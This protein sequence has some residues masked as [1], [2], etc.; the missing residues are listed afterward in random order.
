[1][2]RYEEGY[3]NIYFP[4]TKGWLL[5]EMRDDEINN[6]RQYRE[7]YFEEELDG[8]KEKCQPHMLSAWDDHTEGG[9][10]S[11]GAITEA[12]EGPVVD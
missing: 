4:G 7:I 6:Q 9:Y 11:S 12:S 5:L 2:Q 3:W 10:G 1:M 8:D